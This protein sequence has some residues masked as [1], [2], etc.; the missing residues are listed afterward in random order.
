MLLRLSGRRRTFFMSAFAQPAPTAHTPWPALRTLISG[1]GPLLVARAPRLRWPSADNDPPVKTC[2]QPPPLAGVW[3]RKIDPWSG[4]LRLLA[5]GSPRCPVLVA[6]VP[7]RSPGDFHSTGAPY[8]PRNDSRGTE[9]ARATSVTV[10]QKGYIKG[11]QA[12][13]NKYTRKLK[14]AHAICSFSRTPGKRPVWP[15]TEVVLTGADKSR[16]PHKGYVDRARSGGP[17]DMILMALCSSRTGSRSPCFANIT[18][19]C[20][21]V[22]A[23]GSL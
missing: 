1:T 5:P 17:S 12:L 9:P 21:R 2:E 7:G 6:T 11:L 10:T 18:I 3:G 23:V 4:S 14:R 22:S 16:R 19:V 8:D 20:A 15:T 13:R